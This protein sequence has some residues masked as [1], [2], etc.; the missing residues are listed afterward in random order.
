MLLRSLAIW[1]LLAGSLFSQ[2][3]GGLSSVAVG[4]ELRLP[5]KG[6]T[7]PNGTLEQLV[8][9]AGK[10]VV[11]ADSPVGS[12]SSVDLD[13]GL[14]RRQ[15]TIYFSA[16][17]PGL[18]V[19]CLVDTSSATPKIITKRVQVG[20]VAPTP[21]NPIPPG[22]TPNPIPTPGP[23]PSPAPI[24]L[25]GLRVMVI[26]ET[27]PGTTLLTDSVT[28][29]QSLII[30]GAEVRELLTRRCAK[31]A[32]GHPEFRFYDQHADMSNAAPHWREAFN[33]PRGKL[34][35]LVISDGSKGYEGPLPKDASEFKSLLGGFGQ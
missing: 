28:T 23:T 22:P 25:P 6:L 3:I 9:W 27:K 12:T 18:Y 1:L 34:P 13:I 16:D 8:A 21:P 4:S 24:P 32:K 15:P 33:R 26:Y 5:V 17:S 10:L 29:A 2:E 31:D 30:T 35:W 20:E 7:A 11:G 19:V 14:A